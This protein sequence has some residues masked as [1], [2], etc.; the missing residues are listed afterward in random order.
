MSENTRKSGLTEVRYWKTTDGKQYGDWREA[1]AH[2]TTLNTEPA[3]QEHKEEL[4]AAE[5]YEEAYA[6]FGK[7]CDDV[8]GDKNET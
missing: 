2:Q 7:I 1:E 4:R 3:F 5:T 8:F 6:V